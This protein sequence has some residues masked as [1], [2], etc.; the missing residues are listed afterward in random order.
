MSEENSPGDKDEFEEFKTDIEYHVAD[1]YE[2]EFENGFERN[3]AV[4]GDS[5]SFTPREKIGACY[6]LSNDNRLIWVKE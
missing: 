3:K 6:H 2:S 4:I 1:T 5:K